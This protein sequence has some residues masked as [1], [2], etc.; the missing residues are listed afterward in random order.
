ME[1]QM[2][3]LAN[4]TATTVTG[5]FKV[6]PF[7]GSNNGEVSRQWASRPRDQRYLNLTDLR[8]RLVARREE[9][10]VTVL[11]ARKLEFV[12]PEITTLADAQKFAVGLPGGGLVGPTHWS[13][14]QL[15]GLADFSGRELR[16]L[17]SP[18]VADI[19]TYQMRH[20]R[21]IDELKLFS[22]AG[23]L[24]AAVGPKYGWIPDADVVEAVQMIAGNGTG[25]QR[26]KIPGVMNWASSTYDPFAPVTYD[27]TTLY[28]SDR[29]VFIFLVDDTHPLE[30]GK[31]KNGEPDLLFRGFYMTNSEV[32][33]GALRLATFY[34][35]GVCMNRNLWGVEQFEDIA[36]R[37]TSQA[38]SRFVE[39]ARPA[40][41]S[42]GDASE[43]KLLEGVAAAKAAV[44]AKDESE[45]LS[46]LRERGFSARRA[47]DIAVL[48]GE[49]QGEREEGDFPRTAWDFTQCITEYARTIPNNDERV[50]V[51]KVA[52]KILDKVA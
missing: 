40:L 12:A 35:R 23:E 2:L 21:Q 10:D 46:F 7:L 32:G 44:L 18:L 27:S 9:T 8:E 24:R 30:I 22:G 48:T 51:E 13:F 45:A 5:A 33:A 6:D 34:L 20:A 26:W 3:D 4:A 28:A 41:L 17:P 14:S 15:A 36:I 47:R 1:R 29:D 52:G 43:R 11:P 39:E 25:D 37:H 16:K 31:L 42:Y 50:L 19:L 49:G 38:P